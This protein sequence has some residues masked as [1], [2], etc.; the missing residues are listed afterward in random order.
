MLEKKEIFQM[1]FDEIPSESLELEDKECYFYQ[2]KK[3]TLKIIISNDFPHSL[4]EIYLSNYMDFNKWY[5]HVG[6]EGKLCYISEDNLIW[7]FNNPSGLLKD[8][9]EKVKELLDS[10]DT[11]KMTEELR[12]EFLSYWYISCLK[13]KTKYIEIRSYLSRVSTF[14]K[15]ELV[16]SNQKFHLFN[17][18]SQ[19]KGSVVPHS[20]KSR[21]VYILPLK[22]SNSVIPPNPLNELT[23]ATFKKMITGNL[24]S[25]VRRR[26]Q[27]W[28]KMKRKSFILILSLPISDNDYVL[29]GAHF[30]SR[31]FKY[32]FKIDNKV[33]QKNKDRK[34]L[35][36]RLKNQKIGVST[37]LQY[38][39]QD[40]T[41]SI[42]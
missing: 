22:D 20:K 4:P 16:L 2:Y 32:P 42:E 1:Y 35:V 39:L 33:L 37:L 28:C 19:L 5:S 41:R 21:D 40:S 3:F 9:C 8:C 29:F 30:E 36:L 25:G 26:F 15:Y 27:K 34:K 38:I 6:S 31:T 23:E 12:K 13:S 7:D 17:Y 10:W 11:P 24:S 14:E 18:G